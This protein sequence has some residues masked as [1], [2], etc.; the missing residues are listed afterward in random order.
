ML[1]MHHIAS[2]GW[3]MAVLYRELGACY[4]AFASD[5]LPELPELPIPVCRLRCL[6]AGILARRNARETRQLLEKTDGGIARAARAAD[7]S[8]EAAAAIAPR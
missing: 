4:E 1:V 5:K 2:D 3:S 8:F 7:G 6:A